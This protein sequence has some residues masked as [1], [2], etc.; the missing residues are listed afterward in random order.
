[1]SHLQTLLDACPHVPDFSWKWSQLMKT[2]IGVLL[3]RM[4]EIPQNPVW[5]REG[6]VGPHVKMV[7]EALAAA[8]A[9][10]ML[11]VRSQ[12][13]LSVAALLHDVGKIPN[14]KFEEGKWV[15]PNHSRTGARMA[16][17]LLWKEFDLCG[18]QEKQVFRET[19]CRFIRYHM[20]PG[21][22]LDQTDPEKRLLCVA[23]DGTLCRDFS[24]ERLCMLAQ[25]DTLG[26]LAPDTDDL[27]EKIAL[28]YQESQ[29]LE[30]LFG[31]GRFA[32]DYT[33]RAYFK[34]RNVWRTQN[35]FND[36][37]GEV[38]LL[39]GLPGTGKDTWIRANKPGLPMVSLDKLRRK[40]GISPAEKQG[41]VAQAAKEQAKTYLRA[42]QPFVWNATDLT[43]TTRGSLIAL[44]EDYGAAVRIVYLETD[45]QENLRRNAERDDVVPEHAIENM[46][47]KLVPPQRWE[48]QY[49][50]WYCV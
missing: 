27:L 33:Q 43:E 12:Q 38:V 39:C 4:E 36:T 6:N 44:F 9:F 21:H 20:L 35:L 18:T 50:D 32:D 22:I 11:P 46:L 48:A 24:I 19:I 49:V 30:C 42:R 13:V 47:G 37:W 16:R 31:P 25:A 7:C 15:S 14:T 40:L 5:H 29:R 34:G 10:R 23:A 17:E 2:P 45:W 26:R 8:P 1:M 28:C 41:Y 3:H